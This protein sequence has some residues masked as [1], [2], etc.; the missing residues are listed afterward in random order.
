MQTSPKLSNGLEF[1]EGNWSVT[2]EGMLK[3]IRRTLSVIG[4]AR[5]K[6][7][8]ILFIVSQSTGNSPTHLG[9]SLPD[10]YE[11]ISAIETL[12]ALETSPKVETPAHV[13]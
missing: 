8:L 10:F 9:G 7:D 12:V 6:T 4:L 13:F 2:V 11:H 1:G 3:L 5:A